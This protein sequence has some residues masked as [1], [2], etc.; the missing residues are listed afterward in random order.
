MSKTQNS[1][2]LEDKRHGYKKHFFNPLTHRDLMH[3]TV[4]ACLQGQDTDTHTFSSMQNMPLQTDFQAQMDNLLGAIVKVPGGS[5]NLKYESAIRLR[6]EADRAEASPM[7]ERSGAK[8]AQ[9]IYNGR[10]FELEES[11]DVDPEADEARGDAGLAQSLDEEANTK[12]ARKRAI[13]TGGPVPLAKRIADRQAARQK[14]F[15]ATSVP[16]RASWNTSD[17][18]RSG[19]KGF[20]GEVYPGASS[21]RRMKKLRRQARYSASASTAGHDADAGAA[22]AGSA[23]SSSRSSGGS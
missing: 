16:G 15:R 17:L 1:I 23:D 21:S 5:T 18:G 22:R 13:A 10:I 9:P 6:A 20:D 7:E 12:R 8:Q 11:A 4:V 3:D 19:A 2:S 14:S